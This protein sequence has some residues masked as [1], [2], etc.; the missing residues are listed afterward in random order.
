MELRDFIV[1]PIVI[2]I[3]YAVAY[4]IRPRVTDPITRVYFIPAL[5]VK[6]IGALAVG[7]IYQ[8]YYDGGDTFN[9]H[10]HGSRHIWEAF[11]DSPEKGFKLLFNDGSDYKDV[12]KYASRIV[13][14][15][16]PS[17]YAVVKK[18]AVLDLLTFSTYSAT[19]ILFAVFSFVGMWMFF[20]VFYEKYPQLHT[21]LALSAFF[22]PSVFFWGSGLLKDTITLSCLGMATFA[23]SK[24]FSDKRFSPWY[25]SLLIFALL[26]LYKIKIYILLTFLPAAIVW[27]FAINLRNIRSLMLKALLFP[28]VIGTASFLAYY[29]VLKAGEGNSKYSLHNIAQTAQITAYDIRY[30]TGREAGSGYTLGKLDG[31]FASMIR[32][33]PQAINVSLFRPYLWEVNSS[34]MLLSALESFALLSVC[35]Y[36]LV[37]RNIRIIPSFSSPDIVFTMIFSL[38]FAFAV[39]VSTF[40]FG[41]LARYKIPMFPFFLVGLTLV[42]DY[43][44][45]EKKFSALDKIE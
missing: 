25:W 29:S 17:S 14:F 13:F 19:A 3:V 36:I 4:I 22:V 27:I 39:G 23:T 44:K 33:T 21:W 18:S 43:K 31:S 15:T 35:I 24:T 34:L 8:F 28:L 5:T 45:R 30:W 32:L 2:I 11:M 10:T 26:A 12:Y 38:A 41:S 20:L 7:F 16:D 37:S 42:G 9:Y 40:N 6:I 1:T